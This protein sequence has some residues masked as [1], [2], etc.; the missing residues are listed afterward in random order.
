MENVIT[1]SPHHKIIKLLLLIYPALNASQFKKD[2]FISMFCDGDLGHNQHI[3]LPHN[4]KFYQAF[5]KIHHYLN[6]IFMSMLVKKKHGGVHWHKFPNILHKI[7]EHF[8]YQYLVKTIK[9]VRHWCT[10]R[11]STKATISFYICTWH[12]NSTIQNTASITAPAK[13][14]PQQQTQSVNSKNAPPP[15]KKGGWGGDENWN[16]GTYHIRT[17]SLKASNLHVTH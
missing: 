7:F 9:V 11:I 3:T 4:I 14:S 6:D 13:I 16:K 2:T 15:Q 12:C 5:F 8:Y 1:G 17:Q 10:C